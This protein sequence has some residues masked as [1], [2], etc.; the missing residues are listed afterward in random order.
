MVGAFTQRRTCLRVRGLCRRTLPAA[1]ALLLS[2]GTGA[3]AAVCPGTCDRTDI[4][5]VGS[6]FTGLAGQ[7]V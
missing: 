3:S 4:A 7:C 2:C 1:P 5:N 6:V